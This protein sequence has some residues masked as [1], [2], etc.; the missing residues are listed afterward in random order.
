MKQKTVHEVAEERI[1]HCPACFGGG[2]V[3]NIL[4]DFYELPPAGRKHF[5][6]LQKKYPDICPVIGY[7]PV[8]KKYSTMSMEIK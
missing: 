1:L 7:C 6:E 8:C 3:E 5:E 2:V 4:Y